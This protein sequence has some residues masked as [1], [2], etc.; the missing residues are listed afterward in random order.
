MS[1][2]DIDLY[3]VDT[4]LELLRDTQG[5]LHRVIDEV[6]AER[7][8]AEREMVRRYLASMNIT[9]DVKDHR[10]RCLY[11]LPS[12]P[13][14]NLPFPQIGVSVGSEGDSDWGLGDYTGAEAIEVKDGQGNLTGYDIEQGVFVSGSWQI[15]IIAPGKLEVVWLSRL[16]QLAV[17]R[18]TSE[19]AGQMSMSEITLSSAD[20]E[21][22]PQ[23]FPDIV[24][25][26]RVTLTGKLPH[27][28]TERIGAA[29]YETGV[30]TAIT[31]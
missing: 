14:V 2:P 27:T 31:E 24:F 19:L 21:I 22:D 26:R 16:C 30:N 18:K 7:P 12:L 8:A 29:T 4:F 5:E 6:F 23:Q 13:L 11:V 9:D 15:N 20:I 28:W 25:G 10:D 3:L 17:R 1:F